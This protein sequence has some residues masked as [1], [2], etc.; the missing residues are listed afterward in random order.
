MRAVPMAEYLAGKE[1]ECVHQGVGGWAKACFKG[2]APVSLGFGHAAFTTQ[3]CMGNGVE[4][5]G[6][7]ADQEVKMGG[8]VLG[9][10][11][12]F[13]SIGYEVF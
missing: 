1:C 4:V 11:E 9:A 10:V 8:E 2:G 12:G 7:S 13:K 6:V 3:C 5:L